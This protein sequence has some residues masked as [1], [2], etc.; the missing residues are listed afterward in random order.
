MKPFFINSIFIC[1]YLIGLSISDEVPSLTQHGAGE[2]NGYKTQRLLKKEKSNK[3]KQ[4][5]KKGKTNKKKNKNSSKGPEDYSIQGNY[6]V[7]FVH[8]CAKYCYG[9]AEPV[10]WC[11]LYCCNDLLGDECAYKCYGCRCDPSN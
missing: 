4:K 9:Q 10:M 8:L 5:G 6:D 1:V 3:K 11:K 2:V 7:T